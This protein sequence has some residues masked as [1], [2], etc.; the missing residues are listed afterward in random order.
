MCELDV[1]V[2]RDGALV[3]I[4]DEI[5]DRTTDGH[6]RVAEL[7]LPELK[8]L[9]AGV[10]FGA[11][12]ACE[13]I[14]TL[15]EVFDML[16]DRCGLN[17]ELKAGAAAEPVCKMIRERHA[18]ETTIVSSFDWDALAR[19]KAVDPAIRIGVLSDKRADTM[20]VAAR[21]LGAWAV[22]PRYDLCS[23]EL[24][25]EARRHDLKVLA[26]TVD[27]PIL[28]SR[29]IANGV[30]GIMTNYPDRLHALIR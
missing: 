26:W 25:A 18:H 17:L 27:E 8:L 2:A 23:A 22:N 1:Q 29:M 4:H 14:S 11:R 20:I 6:G 13:R 30:D 3:V 12:F 9:D 10:R 19:V 16:G 7:T 5:V 15:D 21:A 24:V 28:I